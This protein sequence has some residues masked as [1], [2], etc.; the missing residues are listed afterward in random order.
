MHGIYPIVLPHGCSEDKMKCII[1]QTSL[2]VP[3][4]GPKFGLG[5]PVTNQYQQWKALMK[6]W[7]SCKSSDKTVIIL[8]LP[9]RVIT[10]NAA[11]SSS[12]DQRVFLSTLRQWITTA[13]LV[14]CPPLLH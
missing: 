12:L 3:L 7:L 2:L 14:D 4:G 13:T 1:S 6:G 11:L 9:V 5:T 8:V 10:I